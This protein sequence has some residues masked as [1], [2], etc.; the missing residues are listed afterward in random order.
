M[1][2]RTAN[3]Q[4]MSAITALPSGVSAQSLILLSTFTSD[5][6]DDTATFASS[7]D[8]TYKEYIF[9]WADIHPETD[10]VSFQ[11][12][13]RDGGSSYDATKTSSAF[14]AYNDEAGTDAALGYSGSNDL[15]QATGVQTLLGSLGNGNDESTSGELILYDPSSTTYVKHYVAKI[16]YYN[17]S[18]YSQIY[19]I[20]GYCNVTAAIDGV[21]FSMSSDEIQGGTIKMYGV[22]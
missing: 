20:A 9:K 1:A 13:F 21:Q 12:N 7:I 2:I 19:Y 15:A 22:V 11:V 16:Q 14:T 6:S 18:D 5:G 3:N 8:S 17:R 10:N 4:S